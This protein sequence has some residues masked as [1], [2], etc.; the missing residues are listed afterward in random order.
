MTSAPVPAAPWGI[1]AAPDG[2]AWMTEYGSSNVAPAYVG[3]RIASV[4]A[5][6][7]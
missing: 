6:S 4:S 3:N 1:V 2:G 5:G 7:A